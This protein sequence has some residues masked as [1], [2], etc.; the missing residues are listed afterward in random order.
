VAIILSL[1]TNSTKIILKQKKQPKKSIKTITC[2]YSN[3]KIILNTPPQ[4]LP[5]PEIK[6]PAVAGGGELILLNHF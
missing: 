3:L 5:T 2:D 4:M 1:K 6:T